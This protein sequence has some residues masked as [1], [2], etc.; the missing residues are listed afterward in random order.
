MGVAVRGLLEYKCRNA[1]GR[2]TVSDEATFHI[3][4]IL[5]ELTK[6]DV[7]LLKK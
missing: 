3:V 6:L 2:P 7:Q 4:F 5:H 1:D